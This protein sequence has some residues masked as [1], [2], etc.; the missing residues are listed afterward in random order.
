MRRA[1]NWRKC[2]QSTQEEAEE[3]EEVEDEEE[4]E[5]FLENAKC[6]QHPRAGG[7]GEEGAGE[8]RRGS[9]GR[10]QQVD[11]PNLHIK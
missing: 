6:S 9:V 8:G 11:S 1:Q 5:A 7:G 3:L 2:M 4:A 10:A